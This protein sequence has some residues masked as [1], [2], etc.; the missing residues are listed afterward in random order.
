MKVLL[1]NCGSSSIKYKLYDMSDHSVMAAG[2]IEKIGSAGSFIKTKLPKADKTL[3]DIPDHNT[4]VQLVLQT[5]TSPENGCI[6]SLDEIDAVG[7]RIV[8]GGPFSE[9]TLLTPEIFAEW[10]KCALGLAPVHSEVQAKSIEAISKCLPN[11]PQVG[12]FDTAFHQT[13]PEH[14]YLTSLPYEFYEKYGIRRY[15]FHG[16]SFR[17]VLQ[18]SAQV[19]GFNANEKRII[20]CHIGN[21]ISVSAI[22]EGV[23][24]DTTMGMMPNDGPMMGTRTGDMD[25]SALLFL[26]EKENLTPAATLDLISKNSGLLGISGLTNDMREIVEAAQSGHSRAQLALDMYCYRLKRYIG[27]YAAILGGV[28]YIIFTAGVGENQPP[29]RKGCLEGLEFMGVQ[30][31]IETNEKVYGQE[32]VIST[33]DSKVTVAVIPTDEE[34]MMA[35]DTMQVVTKQK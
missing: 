25:A 22:K 19:L 14:A 17:Y 27:A 18:R 3:C 12:I 29:V 30:L 24:I 32:T 10:K 33:P 20:I 31:D 2:G 28:D 8:H 13:I 34:L 26:M 4:G 6:H 7:D 9:S 11:V 1:L 16:T 21:G 5:L 15:G 35:Q 23:C